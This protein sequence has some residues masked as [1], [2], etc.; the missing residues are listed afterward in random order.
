[1]YKSLIQNINNLLHKEKVQKEERF[2]RGEDFNIFRV[3]HMESDEVY[4]HSAV[5]AELLN[6]KGSHGCGDTF[7][8]LFLEL[9]PSPF[10]VPFD[11]QN[12]TTEV[13]VVIGEITDKEGGRMDVLIESKGQAI[14][15]ENKIYAG[16]Q[17]N[18]LLRYYNYAETQYGKSKYKLLYLTL[19]GKS[20]SESSTGKRLEE[21]ENF[22]CI[23]YAGEIRQWLLSCLT[24][25][26]QKPLVRE[27]IVQYI[28]LINK[29]THQ[30]MESNVKAE[31]LELCSNPQNMEA[32]LWISNNFSIVVQKI[33]EKE[34]IPQLQEIADAN[35]FKLFIK[36]DGKDWLNTKWMSFS[37]RKDGWSNF[38]ISFEFQF[39]QMRDCI[40]G[41]RY[42]AE[43]P[44]RKYTSQQYIN[45]R[46]VFD[47]LRNMNLS[48]KVIT[49]Q[50]WPI[51]HYF[52]A[53]KNN[54]ISEDIMTSIIK[55]TLKE[56]I[57]KELLELAAK[58]ENSKI[59]L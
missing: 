31:L 55:G 26:V 42:I 35:G 8:K 57:Q 6:P 28:N 3:M 27:I 45:S 41:F 51:Y 50:R 56:A 15:I 7:L 40:S 25:A 38:E 48:H 37:F 44:S 47:A 13:E 33:M 9:L 32:L 19:D 36:N 24:Q 5:I 12:A 20:P 17:H 23:S 2:K 59:K 30:D 1:M 43:D 34:F 10:D 53:A 39:Q 58:A 22:Y 14:I 54:W 4:T 46:D 11:T 18:Q 21:N 16:D 29:L 52:P 49:S